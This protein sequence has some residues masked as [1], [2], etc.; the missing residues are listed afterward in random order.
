M[1]LSQPQMRHPNVPIAGCVVQDA[2]A[3]RPATAEE[4]KV[5]KKAEDEALSHTKAPGQQN[6]GRQRIQD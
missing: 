2:E 3:A 6:L 5:L 1:A 4:A